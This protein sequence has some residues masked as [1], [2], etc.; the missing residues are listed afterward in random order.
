M[1]M[2]SEVKHLYTDAAQKL[3]Y[4]GIFGKEWFSVPWP[5]KFWTVQN[6][7]LL[8]LIPIVLAIATWGKLLVNQVLIIHTDNDALHFVINKQY[9][10]EDEVKE[11]IRCLVSQCLKFNILIKAR[12]IS[13]TANYLADALS[14]LEVEKFLR[15]YPSASKKASVPPPV[16][17]IFNL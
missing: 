9:S 4:G 14:R 12:H 11:G 3:A 17:S 8:E 7:T 16:E 10:K 5:T 1:F 6:I 2:S 15:L 13:G